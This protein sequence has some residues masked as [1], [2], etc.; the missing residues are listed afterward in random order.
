MAEKK[1]VKKKSSAN[2]KSTPTA[3][4][5][6][7]RAEASAATSATERHG[8]RRFLAGTCVAIACVIIILSIYAVF[9]QQTILD[10]ERY[11][12]NMREIIK[13]PAVKKAVS[14]Y[15]TDE[16]FT[17]LKVQKR[18][19]DVLPEKIRIVAV[20]ATTWLKGFT[21][22]QIEALME[23]KQFQD[24]WVSVNETAHE[25]IVAVIRGETRQVKMTS[26]GTV[27]IDFMPIVKDL[28]LKLTEDT[29]LHSLVSKIPEGAVGPALKTA[30]STAGVELPDDFG[31]LKIMQA[32][33]LVRARQIVAALDAAATWLPVASLLFV[34]LAM[35]ISVGRRRTAMQLG[36]GVTAAAVI[37]TL[38]SQIA[39]E[40][41]LLSIAD[42]TVRNMMTTI[43]EIELRGLP[44][45]FLYAG[46][47]GAVIWAVAFL[48]GKR[49][50]IEKMDAWWRSRIGY[51]TPEDLA[52]HPLIRWINLNVNILRLVLVFTAV[53][54]L[55]LIKGWW[56]VAAFG[57][58]LA[59]GEAKLRYLTG[60][61]WF[62]KPDARA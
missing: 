16:L 58:I 43:V 37:G 1:S 54:V 6:P 35:G 42:D 60:W 17:A 49:I 59:V 21:E 34:G 48:A 38:L 22:Q 10:T 32:K 7:P 4:V 27:Y 19:S 39:V 20:P 53:I 36:A 28:A 13:E 57:M 62:S 5:T 29:R 50:W 41:A 51:A 24:V 11:T 3:A 8:F 26:D 61:Y 52:K 15:A 31:Q 12:A 9:L 23:T 30:L 55:L 33:Q 40:Q 2:K 46:I 56:G 18:I 44:E 45:L 25:N 14:E 47:A